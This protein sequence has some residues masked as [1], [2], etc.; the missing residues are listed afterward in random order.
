MLSGVWRRGARHDP[1]G[2]FA[3][4]AGLDNTRAASAAVAPLVITS[5][6]SATQP[7]SSRSA[8]PG[9]MPK[10]PRMRAARCSRG[11]SARCGVSIRRR[12]TSARAGIDSDAPTRRASSQAWF[13]PRSARRSAESGTGSSRAGARSVA[14]AH[15]VGEQA[16]QSVRE[17]ERGTKLEG[18]HQ[19]A[20]RECVVDRGNAARKG[21]WLVQAGAA[22]SAA[23][24]HGNGADAA[25]WS[26]RGVALQAVVADPRA[27]PATAHRAQGGQQRAREHRLNILPAQAMITYR[28]HHLSSQAGAA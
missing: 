28:A 13:M 15:G 9:V 11:R 6:T 18:R 7:P 16:R 20:P 19:A 23:V 2:H 17:V 8:W 12:N 24:G 10:A 3:G 27:R 22:D 21:R 26:R 4:A 14:R 25:A 5:S 1:D